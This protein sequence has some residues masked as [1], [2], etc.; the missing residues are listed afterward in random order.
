MTAR[1]RE[2]E[3][4]HLESCAQ[5]SAAV[6]RVLAELGASS[7]AIQ[8]AMHVAWRG[9]NCWETDNQ[10]RQFLKNPRGRAPHRETVARIRRSLARVG[11]VSSERVMPFQ[12]PHG[13]KW[14]TAHGT[15]NK[16]ICYQ[17]L[18]IRNPL[19]RAQRR[20]A[21][22]A[23]ATPATPAT[24]ALLRDRPVFSAPAV[25]VEAKKLSHSEL[26][27]MLGP[28]WAFLDRQMQQRSELERSAPP[29]ELERESGRGPPE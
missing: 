10:V 18:G 15:T 2:F 11:Y 21:R 19:T 9:A 22:A 6:A 13:A 23:Q 4:R 24:P 8:Y 29:S 3:R 14:R 1:G 12:K 26:E 5:A 20:D 16:A 17:K 25:I 27:Q 28:A 7:L